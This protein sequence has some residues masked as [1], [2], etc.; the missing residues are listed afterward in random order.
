[1]EPMRVRKPKYPQ[2]EPEPEKPK[3]KTKKSH[4]EGIEVVAFIHEFVKGSGGMSKVKTHILE[5]NERWHIDIRNYLSRIDP[6]TE[7]E[8]EQRGKGICISIEFIPELKEAIAAVEKF[9]N[10]SVE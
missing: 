4:N 3:K 1:M 6:N 5:I 9:L 10:K 8:T 7:E 2:P